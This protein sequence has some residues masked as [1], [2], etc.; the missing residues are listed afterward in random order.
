MNNWLIF[1]I[2]VL[3]G[4]GIELIIDYL[5]WRKKLALAYAKCDSLHARIDG[6]EAEKQRLQADLETARTSL[7]EC[8]SLRARIDSLEAENRRLQADLEAARAS[9]E[10]YDSLRARIDGLEAENQRL[11]NDLEAR[12]QE[13]DTRTSSIPLEES[14]VALDDL[15]KIEGIG[16]KISQLLN[17]A[18]IYTFA[19]LA[20]TEITRLRIILKEA[21][22]RFQ[23]ADPETWPEQ[24]ALAARGA[25]EELRTLQDSLK[26]GRK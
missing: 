6:L 26:G 7:D 13:V 16:V 15:R 25:W 20:G 4:W 18:G 22:P 14:E 5:F 17:A 8:D 12:I 11:Q 3:V 9:L 19:Q 10:D 2:G 21:G 23:L 1:F 24:A